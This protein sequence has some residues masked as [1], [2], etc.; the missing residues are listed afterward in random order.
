MF[1]LIRFHI[2]LYFNRLT[3]FNIFMNKKNNNWP[4]K[5]LGEVAEINPKKSEVSALSDSMEVSFVPMQAVDDISGATINLGR[6]KLGEVRKGYTYFRNNDVL[7]AKITPCMQNGKFAIARNLKNGI[8][9][10]STE[11]HVIRSS[12]QI[13]PEWIYLL[14]RQESFRKKAE[15]HMTGTAGQQRVPKEYLE[16]LEIPVPGIEKQKRIV[17]RL[18]KILAKIEEAWALR[19][20]S[21]EE[22][23]MVI[24]SAL[25]EIFEDLSKKYVKK[26]IKDFGEVKGGKRLPAGH[27]FASLPTEYP[28]LRVVDF[29]DYSID[30]SNMKYLG[31]GT[32]Q[33]ISHYTISDRD[34][35]ISIAGTIGTVGTIPPQLS[36]ANLT[37]N[38]AKIVFSEEVNNR[39]VIYFLDSP[40]GKEEIRKRTNQV[41]QPKLALMR[42]ETIEVPL[43]DL[44]KQEKIVAELDDLSEKV[45]ALQ[46]LQ[47]E[48]LQE[49]ELLKQSVL[50]QAFE[51]KL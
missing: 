31:A 43:P 37:E 24:R 50:H 1:I 16:K 30:T 20:E 40:Q 32:Q 6:R 22:S 44:K 5:K 51:G 38:A 15:K 47:E 45:R 29:K 48:Q 19:Q 25:R 3:L 42:I 13:L 9:F 41:G 33:E 46:K 14:I 36:G 17:K 21:I 12:N 23:Q 35:Y 8:G 10:G 27:T 2:F 4:I 7:F 26:E 28:Y 18:E 34:A 11:F 49:L 39:F